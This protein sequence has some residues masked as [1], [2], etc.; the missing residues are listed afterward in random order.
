MGEAFPAAF[1]HGQS[2]ALDVSPRDGPGTSE[3][4]TSNAD[5]AVP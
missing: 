5:L 1:W 4:L 3:R 2:P